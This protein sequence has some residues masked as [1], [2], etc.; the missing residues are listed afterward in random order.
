MRVLV[1]GSGSYLGQALVT[2]LAQSDVF[3]VDALSSPRGQAPPPRGVE[4]W[5]ADLTKELAPS[6]KALFQAAHVI[7]H[8]AWTRG[9]NIEAV[10]KANRRMVDHLDAEALA[11]VV[12]A[13]SVAAGPR[14]PSVYGA[15]KHEVAETI[16]DA[17]GRVLVL[18]GVVDEPPG[19]SYAELCE[20][21][22]RSRLALRFTGE[23]P[24]LHITPIEQA[25]QGFIDALE[26][27][28]EPGMH[29]LFEAETIPFNTFMARLEARA[30][31]K[32]MKTP[33]WS[34]AL[35]GAAKVLRRSPA[36]RT[37]DRLA[38]FVGRDQAWLSHLNQP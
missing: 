27:R 19:G 35:L 24:H 12:F 8:L 38:S 3:S 9:A 29:P 21:V 17:G 26:G 37:L 10:R 22:A 18:G 33:L 30:P 1:T 25:L 32:R 20:K 2:R 15:V 6:V 28:L 5:S 16:A 14:A 11:R 34:P 13:S 23:E 7:V 4:S 36:G 31:K